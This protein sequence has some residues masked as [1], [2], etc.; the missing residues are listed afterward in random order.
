MSISLV[1]AFISMVVFLTATIHFLLS[2]SV[3]NKLSYFFTL[4]TFLLTISFLL[5]PFN[6]APV[7]YYL[8]SF[9]IGDL[10]IVATLFFC[11]YIIQS[12]E[13]KVLY[14]PAEQKQLT[15]LVVLGGLFLYPLA[16]G[17]GQLDPYR[18]GYQPQIML[19]ILFIVGLYFWY[20][21]YY[22]L[23]FVLTSAVLCFNLRLLESNNLWDYLLDPLLFVVFL[24]I[25]WSPEALA[26]FKHRIREITG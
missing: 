18:L 19:S 25:A 5:M 24:K 9:Y 15:L 20:K 3:T 11:A 17:L 4:L 13:K 2:F 1:Y 16:L 23:V 21:Q 7:F 26:N 8:R 10:S 6:E 12:R 14:Q 22:F